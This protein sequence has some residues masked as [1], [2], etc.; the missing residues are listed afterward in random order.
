MNTYYDF[1]KEHDKDFLREA[2]KQLVA[3]VIDLEIKLAQA[4][5]QQWLDDQIKSKLTGELLVLRRIIFDSKQEKKDKLKKLKKDKKKKNINLVHNQNE[6]KAILLKEG[7]IR[8]ELTAVE[9]EHKLD[10]ECC[11]H[12]SMNNLKDMGLFEESTEFDV[13]ATYYILKRHKRT[14]YKCSHCQK[15][16]TAQGPEKLIDG[17]QFSSQIAVQVACDKFEHHL[18]LERQ[19]LRM[20]NSGLKVSVKTLFSITEH[21][22]N[23][24]FELHELN[25]RDIIQGSHVCI[26]ESPMPFFENDRSSGFVWTMSNARGAYYQFEPTRSGKVALEMIKGFQGI[27]MTD[28]YSGYDFLSSI[29]GIIHVCCWSHVRRYFFNAMSENDHMGTIVDLIDELYAIEHLCQSYQDIKHFRE[30]RSITVFNKIDSW[31]L[32]NEKHFLPSTLSGKAM[33]YY[34]NQKECLTPF[35]T[36]EYVPMDN[37]MAER[38]QRCPVMGKKNYVAFRSINGADV[39]MF[40]YSMIET[41]KT[42]GLIPSAYLLEMAHRK[43]NKEPLQTPYQYAFGLREKIKWK[44]NEDLKSMKTTS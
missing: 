6:H 36:N 33:T 42:N 23:L 44:L 37:N 21:L 40:F 43:L 14:K 41:C 16:T 3:K 24:L 19:R 35:L 32:E 28:G 26:D 15:I 8:P 13:N 29:P 12:C 7:S 11:P 25:R 5:F 27:V 10:S 20:E 30:T 22:Y 39:G 2:G 31:V 1:D 9:V 34:L 38:R 18:P 4:T 17:G